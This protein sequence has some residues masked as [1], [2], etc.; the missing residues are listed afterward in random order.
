MAYIKIGDDLLIDSATQ[1]VYKDGNVLTLPDLSYRLLLTLAECAPEAADRDHLIQ[2]VWQGRVA[3][4]ESLKQRV[5]RLRA[6]IGDKTEKPT[7]IMA[8]RSVGYR[9]LAK[10]EQ[11]EQPPQTATIETGTRGRSISRKS[12]VAGLVIASVVLLG[13]ILLTFYDPASKSATP[14]PSVTAAFEAEDYARQATDYYVRYRPNDNEIAIQL[15]QQAIEADPNYSDAYAGLANAYAQ[16]YLQFGKDYSWTEIALGHA[17][18]AILLQPNRAEGHKALG[19][20]LYAQGKFTAAITAN[21]A[22]AKLFPTWSVPIN[23]NAIIHQE[24]GNL[25]LAYQGNIRAIQINVKDPIPYLHL[26]NSFRDLVMPEHAQRAYQDALSL[27]PGY[28]LA[29]NDLAEFY[30]SQQNY[31]KSLEIVTGTLA[32]DPANEHALLR[33]AI[34]QWMMGQPQAAME[35]FERASQA[36]RSKFQI[37]AQVRLA[38]LQDNPELLEAAKAEVEQVITS[39]HEWSV[40]PYLLSLIHAKRGKSVPA[41][42][43]L[44]Q[45]VAQGFV[46]YRW[47]NTDPMLAAL[48]GNKDFKLLMKQIA[49]QV[50]QMRE[51]VIRL[52]NIGPPS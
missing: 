13:L 48:H 32:L 27:K 22:S 7:Y 51:R 17:N 19:L 14:S 26:G 23:N 1:V 42:E 29:R 43:S 33:G 6:A 39:G 49:D 3:T 31:V 12:L 50:S 25:F 41:L 34:A 5:T 16:G 4:D 2:S 21:T 18:K 28:L 44:H 52:E 11:C 40:Y 35:Y 38:I 45:A 37:Q 24:M 15:Y 9:L 46:D 36:D 8:V 20:A 30:I 10:V 47:A